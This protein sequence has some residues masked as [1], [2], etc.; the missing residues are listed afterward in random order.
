MWGLSARSLKAQ[1]LRDL[2]TIRDFAA[3]WGQTAITAVCPQNV[4]KRPCPARRGHS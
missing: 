3:I 4:G 2:S 1:Q